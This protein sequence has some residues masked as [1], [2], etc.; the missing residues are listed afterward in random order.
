[1]NQT[2]L[3]PR[4][5]PQQ[6]R[7]RDRV[8]KI[9]DA[10]EGLVLETGY[11]SINTNLIAERAEMPVG[12]VYRYFSNK[13]GIYAAVAKR[14]FVE[15]EDEWLALGQP[16]PSSQTVQ[17]YFDQVVDMMVAFWT[18]RKAAMFLWS[19]LRRTPE[20]KS[21]S[22]DFDRIVAE[23]NAETLRRYYPALSESHRR[24]AGLVI[25]ESGT[26]LLNKLVTTNAS[27][28]RAIVTE[29]KRLIRAYVR[30]LGEAASE[31]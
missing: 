22:G 6:R 12:T 19:I 3:K 18:S 27:S 21:V 26:A 17:H 8:A 29:I 10:T 1:M 5:D 31:T 24:I 11:D 15:L 25:E 13:Y 7:S 14:A 9:L 30:A 4:T 28:R 23:R 2:D 20:M 16:D